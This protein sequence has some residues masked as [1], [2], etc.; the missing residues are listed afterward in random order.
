MKKIQDFMENKFAPLA[1]KIDRNKLI[2]AL[3]AGFSAIMPIILVG[4]ISSLVLGFNYF[5]F[6]EILKSIG[7][8]NVLRLIN[9]L[10]TNSVSLYL[11]FMIAYNLIKLYEEEKESLIVGLIS[12]VVF[13]LVTPL[14]V[15]GE[16]FAAVTNL[17]L[18][19]LGAKGMFMAIILG[20]TIPSLYRL[21]V[22]LK[23]IIKMPSS[24]PPMISKSF[25]SLVPAL[26]ILVL[27]AYVSYGMSL[28]TYGSLH[29]LIYSILEKPFAALS[30]SIWTMMFFLL[31]SNIFW[32]FG[33]HG[34]MIVGSFSTALFTAATLQN[35]DAYASGQELEN[36]ITTGFQDLTGGGAA[37]YLAMI[38]L[39]FVSCKR[40]E[41]KVLGKIAAVPQYFGISEPL[42]FGLP[43]IFNFTLFIPLVIAPAICTLLC[44][45]G[46]SAGLI[47]YPRSASAFGTPYLLSGFIQSGISGVIWQIIAVGIC[48]V[49]FYP[50]MKVY[51]KQ[52]SLEDVKDEV[53][54]ER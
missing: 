49:I 26:I 8:N 51:D 6:Q 38:I 21:I 24:V 31:C 1:V 30:G 36:I 14:T 28:T 43:T 13:L 44:Y 45:L 12:L 39:M 18:S 35:I 48:V 34:G 33:I 37:P 29:Q 23:L 41:F 25:K 11:V 15:S 46:C 3:M 52:K 47:A 4:S 16:G 10:T 42:R 27:F 20:F 17:P 40:K 53:D 9:N 2:K 54:S 5:G 19:W 22:K 32:F 50:F 7:A